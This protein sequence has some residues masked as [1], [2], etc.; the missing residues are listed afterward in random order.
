VWGHGRVARLVREQNCGFSQN[1]DGSEIYFHCNNGTNS[2]FHNPAVGNEVRFFAQ[3]AESA[4][5]PH[6]STV[7][8]LGASGTLPP[9]E[10][11]RG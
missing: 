6:R 2:G 9:T 3:Y 5:G 1:A 7:V 8:L 4:E 10:A 11:I